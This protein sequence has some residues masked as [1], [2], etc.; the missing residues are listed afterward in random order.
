M[1]MGILFVFQLLGSG[2]AKL[3]PVDCRIFL[4]SRCIRR[5]FRFGDDEVGIENIE[6]SEIFQRS[7]SSAVAMTQPAG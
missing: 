5:L 1:Q 2:N 4:T 3:Q 6:R 7:E